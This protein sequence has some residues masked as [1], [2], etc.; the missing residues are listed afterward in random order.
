MPRI[1]ES[2][3]RTG[4]LQIA[5][6]VSS[7]LALELLHACRRVYLSAPQLRNSPIFFNDMGQFDALFPEVDTPIVSLAQGLS[8]LAERGARVCVAYSV[9]DAGC[10]AFLAALAPSVAYRAASPL[11]NHGLFGEDYCLQGSLCFTDSGV[12]VGSDRAELST[13]PEVVSRSLLEMARYWEELA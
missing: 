7:L 6:C 1:I 2:G 9:T 3:L 11:R 4:A 5:G 8:I 10:D 13:D 12:D